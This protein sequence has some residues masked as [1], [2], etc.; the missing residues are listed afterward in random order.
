MATRSAAR[1]LVLHPGAPLPAA[2]LPRGALLCAPS[3]LGDEAISHLTAAIIA[4]GAGVE[5]HMMDGAEQTPATLT[6]ELGAGGFN[7]GDVRLI[8]LRDAQ[9]LDAAAQMTLA[10]LLSQIPEGTLL[11]LWAAQFSPPKWGK[12]LADAVA[13]HARPLAVDAPDGRDLAGWVR[14]RAERYGGRLT[15]EAAQRLVASVG[16][17]LLQL[18]Q[19]AQKL[20]L[21]TQG[22]DGG[23]VTAA[24]VDAVVTPTATQSIFRLIDSVGAGQRDQALM[25]LHEL[26]ARGDESAIGIVALLARHFRLLWQARMLSDAGWRGEAGGYPPSVVALLPVRGAVNLPEVLKRQRWMGRPLTMQAKR[27]EPAQLQRVFSRLVV[28]D[29]AL[30]RGPSDAGEDAILQELVLDLCSQRGR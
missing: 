16:E 2:D 18:D 5:R 27:F 12:P 23:E 15:P 4:G 25:R 29:L 21:L 24:V 30:K 9:D 19:E 26:R 3:P 6:A 7:F 10:P 28:A 14:Q 13:A 22:G 1:A 17:N 11:L 8:I 20:A